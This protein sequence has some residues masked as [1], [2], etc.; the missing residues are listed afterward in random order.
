VEAPELDGIA[1]HVGA[2]ANTS[3][4]VPQAVALGAELGD[5]CTAARL[6]ACGTAP[7]LAL[8]RLIS[9]HAGQSRHSAESCARG[10]RPREISKRTNAQRPPAAT[11][12]TFHEQAIA[13]G[14]LRQEIE[15]IV[16]CL[17]DDR[18]NLH[19]T[20]EAIIDEIEGEE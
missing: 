4:Q 2:I 16:D 20:V 9:R 17:C 1:D 12:S 3:S 19:D 8:C 7:V 18:V 14:A 5:T 13:L 11:A 15:A 6:T 10:A